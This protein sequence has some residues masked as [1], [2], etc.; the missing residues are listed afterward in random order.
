MEQREFAVFRR[1]YSLFLRAGKS[2]KNVQR[3]IN[4]EAWET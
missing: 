2:A 4:I 1:C 3:S